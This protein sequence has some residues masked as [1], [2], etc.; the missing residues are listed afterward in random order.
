MTI[1]SQELYDYR[2]ACAICNT[3][4]SL[5]MFAI[6]PSEK[7]AIHGWLFLCARCRRDTCPEEVKVILPRERLGY[8]K[9]PSHP[10]QE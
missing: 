6:R 8:E 4:T 3:R 10:S 9:Q 5:Y 2:T 1:L 7:S